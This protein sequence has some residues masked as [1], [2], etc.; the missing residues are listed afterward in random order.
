M[1]TIR[2]ISMCATSNLGLRVRIEDGAVID[3]RLP[4]T[5]TRLVAEWTALRR[6]ALMRNWHAARTD[7]QLERIEGLE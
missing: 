3:G 4:P 7:G 1:I 5:V 2:P 6:D